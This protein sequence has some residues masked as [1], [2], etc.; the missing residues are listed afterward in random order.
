MQGK[1]STCSCPS[2]ECRKNHNIKI[3][4]KLFANVAKFRHLG[5]IVRNEDYIHQEIQN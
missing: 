5:M 1:L 3:A 2:S 4:N